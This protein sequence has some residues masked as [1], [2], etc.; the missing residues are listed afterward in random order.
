M[1]H[2]GPLKTWPPVGTSCLHFVLIALWGYLV[3]HLYLSSATGREK[4]MAYVHFS[5]LFLLHSLAQRKADENHKCTFT[6]SIVSP[7]VFFHVRGVSP[8]K[9]CTNKTKQANKKTL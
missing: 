2:S 3:L 4:E 7:E 6:E 9:N 1:G 8:C 5:P